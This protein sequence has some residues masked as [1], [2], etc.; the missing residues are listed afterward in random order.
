MIPGGQ[1]VAMRE[2]GVQDTPL[3]FLARMFLSAAAVFDVR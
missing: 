1:V 2:G 3:R